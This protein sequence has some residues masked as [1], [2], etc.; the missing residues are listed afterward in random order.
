[1]SIFF[2]V[3]NVLLHILNKIIGL[4]SKNKHSVVT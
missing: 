2:V 4:G 3:V 1:M